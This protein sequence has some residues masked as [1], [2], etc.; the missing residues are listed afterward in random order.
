MYLK[1]IVCSL[2]LYISSAGLMLA[3]AI[4]LNPNHPDSYTVVKGDTLW[5]ISSTF[6]SDPWLWPEIWHVNPAIEN[7]HL[8]YPGDI[9]RLGFID[10][11][12]VLSLERGRPTIKLSPNKRATSIDQ[13]IPTIPLSII[14]QFLIRPR[15]LSQ[16]DIDS[17]AYIVASEDN[18]LVSGAGAKLYAR[19]L[20]T[21]D[22]DLFSLYHIGAALIDP[23]V[24]N[25]KDAVLGYEAI[26][27]ADLK[28]EREG[29]PSTLLITHSKREALIGDRVLPRE[30]DGFNQNFIPR[31]PDTEVTGQIIHVVDG[32]SRIGQY[33]VVVINVGAEDGIEAGHVMTISQTGAV[34]RDTIKGKG[35]ETVTLP[36]EEVGTLMIF[37][38]HEKASYAL[39]MTALRDIRLYDAVNTPQ[40]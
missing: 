37:R 28:L 13:A 24:E 12:P 7:P 15:V 2:L 30:D 4:E 36:D 21:S 40:P 16:Q 34:V 25:S 6:L 31:A 11:Q 17:A 29:D 3:Q 1:H 8:I 18:R 35:N 10:G 23:T 9:I 32:V 19:E 22:S 14:E 26:H 39:I 5:D 33:Q 27:V 20:D 38:P